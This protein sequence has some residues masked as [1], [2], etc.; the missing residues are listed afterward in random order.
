MSK[1]VFSIFAVSICFVLIGTTTML[2]A[3]NVFI[4]DTS[5]ESYLLNNSAINTNTDAYI[6]QNEAATFNGLIDLYNLGINNLTG[7]EAFT[8]LRYLKCPAN[9]ITNIDVSNNTM[10]T[11][12]DCSGNLLTTLNV[13]NNILLDTLV[14]DNNL[15][16]SLNVS[17]CS[18]LRMLRCYRNNLNEIIL[19]N[20]SV[21]SWLSCGNNFLTSL[22]LSNDTLLTTVVCW[23]NQLVELDLSQNALLEQLN[24]NNNMLQNLDVSN[25]HL[26]HYLYCIE[27]DLIGLNIQNTNNQNFSFFDCTYN[28]SLI[29]IQV[30]SAEYMNDDWGNA[31]DDASF[32]SLSCL[33]PTFDL[34][35]N[36]N[37]SFDFTIS[38]N[39]NNGIFNLTVSGQHLLKEGQVSAISLLGE[40]VF[41]QKFSDVK[42]IAM[43]LSV[44]TNGVYF[45]RLIDGVS[46]IQKRMILIK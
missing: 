30:D 38:P 13:D 39:P 27:N 10:L 6:Q 7:I 19:P 4:P 41:F 11:T 1:F 36:S 5:F 37:L 44:L 45:I 31:K 8:S 18:S 24:C 14:C 42:S 21:L 26:L 17:N 23:N 34:A 9:N 40:Q 32:Y 43:D 20:N 22:N 2:N 33:T 28:P 25:N 29:C 35:N 12:F 3:Q 15:L 16:T 46:T